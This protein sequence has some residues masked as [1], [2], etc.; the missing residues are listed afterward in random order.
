MMTHSGSVYI[1]SLAYGYKNAIRNPYTCT[2]LFPLVVDGG[3]L[4]CRLLET[5]LLDGLRVDLQ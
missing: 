3:D 5:V 1:A 2:V 4:I